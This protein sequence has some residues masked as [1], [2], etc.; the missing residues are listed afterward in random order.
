MVYFVGAGTGAADLI[1]VRGMRLLQQADVIIYAGS[2][3]NPKLLSYAQ[4]TCEIHDS[5]KL[6]LDEVIQI[7]SDAETLGKKT[8]R[9]HTGDPSLY[10]AIR[11]QMDELDKRGISYESCPGVSACFGASSSLN[12]SY[13]LPGISQSLIIT[14]ME[15][16]TKVP[17]RESIESFA[18]HQ[19]SMAIYLSAGRIEELC[20][21]LLA[22]GYKKETPVALV[23]K[24]TWPEEKAYICTVGTLYDTA[25]EHG[26]RKT[27]L[28]LVGDAIAHQNYQKSR[29]YAPDFSTE[30]RKGREQTSVEEAPACPDRRWRL[31]IIS[32]TTEGCR[33]SRQAVERLDNESGIQVSLFTAA[34]AYTEYEKDKE[35]TYPLT[36]VT[37]VCAWTKEQMGEGNAI[38]FIGACGIAVRMAAPHLT[39]K[40][41]DAP[42]LVMDEKGHH[43]IPILSGHMGGGNELALFLAEKLG[44]EPVI[45]TA[46]DLNRK[47]AVDLFARNNG[48]AIMNKEG[49]AKVS[50]K[51]LE[52][53]EITISIE[54]GHCDCVFHDAHKEQCLSE[55]A[56]LPQGVHVLPYPPG[57]SVDVLVTSKDDIKDAAILLKPKKY[58]IGFGCKKG[59][60]LEEIEMFIMQKLRE[61]GISKKQIAA[62]SSISQKQKEA[63][64]VAWCKRERIPFTTYTAE[65]LKQVEGNFAGSDFVKEQVGVDNVCERAALKS[66]GP[67]GRIIMEKCAKNGMTIAIAEREWKVRF[68]GE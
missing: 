15:G 54:P 16:N 24:A 20:E 51:A 45:T 34:R 56:V 21:R 12:L 18:A 37:S 58:V 28:I 48:L 10:G 6:T 57:Q 47:F 2:L 33:R 59:K 42:V 19:A 53:K 5:A 22:G 61:A 23:Y 17:E 29:L 43:V 68:Y 14:R 55:K 46:T 11:E 41:H 44:A 63:G 8:V 40:L 27:A 1:T 13:T 9:L 50:A 31:S 35:G 62:L 65:E 60:N 30:F 39:D 32:F 49:I 25:R 66:C 67:S 64:L 38:L 3:V 52:G 7:I 4:K 26:I 36:Y